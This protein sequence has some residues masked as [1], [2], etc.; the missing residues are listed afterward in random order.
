MSKNKK[1]EPDKGVYCCRIE[2]FPVNSDP[3]YNYNEATETNLILI[4]EV[5]EGFVISSRLTSA[6]REFLHNYLGMLTEIENAIQYVSECYIK[7]DHDIGD[8]L[9]KSVM[10]G[11]TPYNEEN[12]TIQ[13]IFK[14]DSK[15]LAALN[16]FQEAVEEAVNVEKI[17]PNEQQRMKFLHER[18]LPRKHEWTQIVENYFKTH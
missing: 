10:L 3:S 15:A 1:F 12:M 17:Y 14:E 7:G 4:L 13:A 8:R 18:L 16:Q 5:K 2:L 6:K 9:L 11:L